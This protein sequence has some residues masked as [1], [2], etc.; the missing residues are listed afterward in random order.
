MNSPF[1]RKQASTRPRESPLAFLR[2][3]V[4]VI[5]IG[6]AFFLASIVLFAPGQL[7][8]T[9]G[10]VAML[11]VA[12]T[13]AYLLKQGKARAAMYCLAVGVWASITLIVVLN[14]GI[15]VPLTYNYP[16]IIFMG[17]WLLGTRFAISTTVMTGLTIGA[18]V[19]AE[20]A[21]WLP[22]QELAPAALFGN[23][24]V[25]VCIAAAGLVHFL[26]RDYQKQFIEIDA[27]SQRFQT[28]FRSSPV[29]C[30][31]ATVD[32]G[33]I[34][35]VNDNFARDFGWTRQELLGMLVKDIGLWTNAMGRKAWVAVLKQN[36]RLVDYEAT[37]THKNGGQRQVSISAEVL[38]LD[39]K[40]CIL[41]YTTDVT[42][43][44][45]L[46]EQIKSL[47]FYDPLTQLPNRRM[48]LDRLKRALSDGVRHHANGAL[49]FIDLDNFK[50]LN[51][52]LGHDKG[53]ELLRLVAQRLREGVR[54][55]DTVARLGGDEFVVMLEGLDSNE[56]QATAQA[57]AV[58]EK[59][60]AAINLGF[61][62]ETHERFIS[63]SMGITLFGIQ[64]ETVDEPLRRAD[65]AMYQSKN[66]GRNTICVFDPKMLANAS[67]HA[68]L[69]QNLREAIAQ[70]Q[71]SA[72]YQ[73]QVDDADHLTGAELLLRWQHPKRGWVSPA[74]FIPVAEEAAIIL[75]LG[76]WVLDTAC[77]QLVRWQ[78]NPQFA[79]LTLS[80]NV[81][82]RQFY[83]ADFAS[84]VMA[85]LER[86]GADGHRLI[87]ELTESVL[88]SNVSDVVAKM[89][90]LQVMGVRFS[91]DDFGTG[92]SSLSYL[93]RLPLH[94]LKIDQSFVR[95]ILVDPNDAAI[96]KTVIVLAQA[97][98][99]R[100]VAEGVETQAQKELLLAHGCPVFQG[101]FFSHPVPVEDF[102]AFAALHR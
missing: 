100:V 64:Q 8:R 42:E 13:G 18:V 67:A 38:E 89:Q 41:A 53:D 87:L 91:L 96:A 99:L 95:D 62:L 31:I 6:E 57:M 26:V 3:T 71:F 55:G 25:F 10:P 21:G 80:V 97:L 78:G 59:I 72:H 2:L 52:S 84:Q 92:F 27:V 7:H 88:L 65:L 24:L 77:A 12:L 23:T 70:Q 17:G 98:G 44:R 48:L 56:T 34:L 11:S 61:K 90:V 63:P 74:D 51:D 49:L 43:R 69:E 1:F 9:A 81:S 30:S 85:T 29:A 47:A 58:A 50:N 28:A 68:D 46:D 35:E 20:S 79:Q 14:G 39:G 54:D 4:W 102:E 16:L 22:H 19:A 66:A 83:Q 33:R 101:Y 32:D 94:E 40:T 86:H 45:R 76:Q 60:R 82:A 75:T 93:K 37:W 15:R 73:P 5:I 36:G